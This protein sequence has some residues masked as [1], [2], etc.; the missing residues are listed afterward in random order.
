MRF[1]KVIETEAFGKCPIGS[2]RPGHFSEDG[3]CLCRVVDLRVWAQEIRDD[4]HRD[5][6]R[7]VD[8]ASVS[9]DVTWVR[10]SAGAPVAAIVPLDVAYA[11]RAATGRHKQGD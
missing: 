4:E 7:G 8:A 2:L 1:G 11:G 6:R 10:N 5:L 3:T 9:G